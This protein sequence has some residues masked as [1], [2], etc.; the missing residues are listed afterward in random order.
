MLEVELRRLALLELLERDEHRAEIRPEG[1]EQERLA[2]DTYR[3]GNALGLDGD[4]ADPPDDRLRSFQRGRVGQLDVDQHVA[5][6]LRR[7]EPAR[8]AHELSVGE[9]EQAQVN[10]EHQGEDAQHAADQPRVKRG[11]GHESA[12][13]EVEEPAQ[14]LVE[15]SA[16]RPADEACDQAPRQ[17]RCD[18]GILNS[19]PAEIGQDARGDDLARQTRGLHVRKQVG[20]QP[21]ES[22][23]GTQSQE[24]DSRQGL[25]ISLLARPQEH[26]REGRAEGQRVHR[27]QHGRRSDRE[28]ELAK[29]LAG[30]SR[31]ERTRNEHRREHQAH[32][33]HRRRHLAHRLDR[34]VPGRHP[35]L[36]MVL[37]RLDHHDR[38]VHHDADRQHQAE[39]RQVVE[40]ETKRRHHREGT[41]DPHRHRDQGDQRRPPV[42]QEQQD[43]KCHQRPP[44]SSRV[45]NTSWIDSRMNG[46]VS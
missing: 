28:R 12:V 2:R 34:R 9:Q 10:Q 22:R 40:R 31:D 6:V 33:D 24:R 3:G 46:V 45:L 27:R 14:A 32:R 8:R 38:V 29:E 26:G 15:R 19:L 37:D 1:V 4:F 41:D 16:D 30:D 13:E 36:D 11:G 5:H 7:D 44:E 18:L 43:H 21:D 42:L 17:A 20:T 25:V 35:V 39:Q 23:P